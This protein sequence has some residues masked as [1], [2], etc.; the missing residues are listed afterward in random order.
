MS[1]KRVVKG[2]ASNIRP[3]MMKQEPAIQLKL[4]G[5][6]VTVVTSV[7]AAIEEGDSVAVAMIDVSRLGG[8]VG[9]AYRNFTQETSGNAYLK[10]L[11]VWGP[12]TYLIAMGLTL[13]GLLATVGDIASGFGV[14]MI[15]VSCLF[16]FNALK[17]NG[18]KSAVKKGVFALSTMN[19]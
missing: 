9:L 18:L 4:D 3:V 11:S 17:I 15:L 12:L 8:E 7:P 14:I 13:L 19:E 5:K 6:T 10:S 16:W 1:F 2:N